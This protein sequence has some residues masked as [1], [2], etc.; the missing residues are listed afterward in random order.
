MEK[1]KE[2]VLSEFI[3]LSNEDYKAKEWKTVKRIFNLTSDEA[4][5]IIPTGTKLEIFDK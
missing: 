4:V 2:K 1:W 5:V 3:E